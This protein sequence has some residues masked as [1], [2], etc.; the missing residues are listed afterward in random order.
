MS[1]RFPRARIVF[2]AALDL[3]PGRRAEFVAAASNGD[4]SLRLEVMSLL[5]FAG[6][7]D[8]DA[9]VC[10]PGD[11]RMPL[12]DR[13]IGT[14]I[15]RYTIR[16]V[17]GEGGFGSVY[18]AEQSQPVVRKVALKIIKPGMDSANVISRFE[19]ERQALALLR[20]RSVARMFDGGAT[21]TGHPFFVMEYIDGVPIA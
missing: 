8:V 13:L 18:L 12:R 7:P 2:E 17:I 10:D 14:T 20:H 15:G 5:R 1:K 9:N 21:E 19:A 11:Y 4:E 3:P 6:D 16:S